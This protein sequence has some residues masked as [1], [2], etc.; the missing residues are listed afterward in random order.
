MFTKQ[1]TYLQKILQFAKN[2]IVLKNFIVLS[3]QK[4]LLLLQNFIVCR[5]FYSTQKIKRFSR[6]FSQKTVYDIKQNFRQSY[7]FCK[8]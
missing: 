4:P 8:S 1:I 6:I 2:I 5:K 3:S 7:F